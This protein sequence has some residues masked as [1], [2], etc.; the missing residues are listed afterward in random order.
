M[1]K[2]TG[3]LIHVMAL[4]LGRRSGGVDSLATLFRNR[5]DFPQEHPLF[6]K[7]GV[8]VSGLDIDYLGKDRESQ[9]E[10]SDR[11]YSA[12]LAVAQFTN[13]ELISVRTNI[14]SLNLDS[15]FYAE[16]AHGAIL[17]GVAMLLSNEIGN[18]FVS[19]TND[20][21]CLQRWGSSPLLDSLYSSS[22]LTL[23]HDSEDLSRLEKL[24][25]FKPYPLAINNLRVCPKVYEIPE[26][27]LNCGRCE[28]C[29]RTRLEFLAEGILDNS[30][31]FPPGNDLVRL[32]KASPPIHSTYHASQY[33][34]LVEP[35]REQGRID[36]AE[37]CEEKLSAWQKYRAWQMGENFNG[38]VKRILRIIFK[39]KGYNENDQSFMW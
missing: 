21:T 17:A 12:M 35:L 10:L 36:L 39:K 8:L 20:L 24:K 23:F 34:E 14:R 7:Y 38:L 33:R 22:Q 1:G 26:G 16:T 29:L 9:K 11:A 27:F 4:N 28:K 2:L 37:L 15:N 25:V 18:I 5:A 6:I 19:S 13:I 32:V 3:N 31:C 30:A